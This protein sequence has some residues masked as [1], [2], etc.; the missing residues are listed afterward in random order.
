MILKTMNDTLKADWNALL[1]KEGTL[2]QKQLLPSLIGRRDGIGA[3][4]KEV[5]GNSE[6]NQN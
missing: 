6:N 5:Y 2:V 4:G 3:A 1:R